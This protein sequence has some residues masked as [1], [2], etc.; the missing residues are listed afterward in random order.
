MP[1]VRKVYDLS[2]T[3]RVNPE[4][5]RTERQCD[6]FC[7]EWKDLNIEF[8]LHGGASHNGDARVHWCRTCYNE[9]NTRRREAER[10]AGNPKPVKLKTERTDRVVSDD[11]LE[12]FRRFLAER[13]MFHPS[14][15]ARSNEIYQVYQEWD[16]AIRPGPRLSHSQLGQALVGVEG[17]VRKHDGRENYYV[18]LAPTDSVGALV[19][20]SSPELEVVA[21]AE[22]GESL[23]QESPGPELKPEPDEVLIEPDSITLTGF[24]SSIG[25]TPLELVEVAPPIPVAP[26]FVAPVALHPY[27]QIGKQVYDTTGGALAMVDF[28]KFEEK[29]EIE[30]VTRLLDVEPKTKLPVIRSFW[31]SG[32]EARGVIAYLNQ[33]GLAICLP[34]PL[35]R[36]A[37]AALSMAVESERQANRL[38]AELDTARNELERK[39]FEIMRLQNEIDSVRGEHVDFLRRIEPFKQLLE[40]VGLLNG[41]ANGKSPKVAV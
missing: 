39:R 38:A 1:K 33:R 18:G 29:G 13:I 4:T 20:L 17:V 27:V 24:G 36:D 9:R 32:D 6:G 25:T 19:A 7:K 8:Y 12:V 28:S 2:I 26:S 22:V 34:S 40:A 41:T 15:S 31:Y 21:E 14:L 35:D 30:V 10:Q 23:I 16:I 5:G 3:D 37:E 11:R